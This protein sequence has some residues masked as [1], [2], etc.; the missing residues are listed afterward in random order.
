[1]ELNGEKLLLRI[2]TGSLDKINS[3]PIYEVIVHDAK[4]FGIAGATVLRGIMSYG[5]HGFIH[6]A[7][8]LAVSDDLPIVIEIIDEAD[9]IN[10]FVKTIEKY[11]DNPKH[12]GLITLEKVHVIF[13]QSVISPE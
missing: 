11:F 9:K 2:F 12:R 6:T 13:H 8:L 5:A 10:A 1:M 3:T 7:K 4:D